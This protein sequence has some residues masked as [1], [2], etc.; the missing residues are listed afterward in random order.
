MEQRSNEDSS[1]STDSATGQGEQLDS[2]AERQKFLRYVAGLQADRDIPTFSGYMPDKRLST[3]AESFLF[4]DLHP[5][6]RALLIA[7]GT[8]TM[9]I[10][11]IYREPIEVVTLAQGEIEVNCEIPQL[12]VAVGDAV[13]Y[14]EVEL[15]GRDSGKVYVHAYSLLKRAAIERELWLQLINREIGMGVVLRS[16]SKG[17]F[18]Q[19][20]HIGGGDLEGRSGY[21]HRSYS[22]QMDGEPGILI[23]EVFDLEKFAKGYR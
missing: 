8:V 7:D 17:N 5:V 16:A 3:T 13:F 9:A 6:L 23:T 20:L 21:V 11:A 12:R 15:R 14:R 4:Y 22:V 2:N 10:E 18:R 1:A 19:V